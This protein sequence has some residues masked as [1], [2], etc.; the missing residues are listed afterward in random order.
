M[1]TLQC[2]RGLFGLD[3]E[4]CYLNCAAYSPLLLA[5][6]AAG[7]EGIDVKVN[8]QMITAGHHFADHA[9]L[10]AKIGEFLHMGRDIDLQEEADRIAIFP[11]VSYGLAIVAKNLH[12]LEGIS[13]KS[14]IITIHEEFPNDT[15]AFERIAE[16]L[17]LHVVQV[18]GGDEQEQD[19]ATRV[20]QMGARWNENILNAITTET[21]LVVLPH[22]HWIYGI[23]FSL[24]RIGSKCREV[25]ALLVIDGSQSVGAQPF[26]FEAIQPDAL[27]VAA[28]KWMLGPYSIAFGRFGKFF[29]EG[30][31]LEESWMNRANSAD[32]SS[33]TNHESKYRPLA[34][35]YNMGEFS[36]F[37][38]TPMLEVAVAH[39]IRCGGVIAINAYIKALTTE[40]VQRMKTLGV[41][42]VADE[43]RANHIFGAILPSKE[44]LDVAQFAATLKELKIYVSVRG[45]ALRISVNTFNDKQDLDKLVAA[46]EK[47]LL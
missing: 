44:G 29:D 4:V 38:H 45:S 40:A 22:V 20:Q 25:G 35:R 9:T 32:F 42:F 18:A 19:V 37:I 13:S 30:V 5:A 16:E 3:S 34:Q 10:R 39:L 46:M 17:N 33:L 24:E 6:K 47:V 43:F 27:I 23:V 1:S 26:D 11:S 36:E 28:Y 2:Q 31:P 21:A 14:N 7:I 41:Q 8:P 15:Y 12:R